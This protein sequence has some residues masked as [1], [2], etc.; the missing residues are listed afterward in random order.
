MSRIRTLL[1]PLL[2]V[3]R[4]NWIA[5]CVVASSESASRAKVKLESKVDKYAPADIAGEVNLLAAAKYTDLAM[6]F[7]NA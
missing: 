6:N 2:A 3:L 4:L 5:L 7:R 1:A